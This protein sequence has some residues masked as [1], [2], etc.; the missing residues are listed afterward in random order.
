MMQTTKDDRPIGQRELQRLE[1]RRNLS[2]HAIRLFSER[3]FDQTTVEEIAAAAGVSTRTFFLHFPTK[4]AAAFPDH[5]E[6][7]EA[8]VQRLREGAPHADPMSHLRQ[9][10]LAGFD[11]TSPTRLI[12][13]SLLRESADLRDEDART[14][15]DYE[16]VIADFLIT[17]WG[18]SVEATVRAHAGANATIGVVRAALVAGAEHGLDA[19]QVTGEILQRMFGG[20]FDGPLHSVH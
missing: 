6:R 8:V 12:R 1:T 4:A 20:P 11:T 17:H 9:V 14:D 13:Y 3:G 16:L 2:E 15:R 5:G 18:S 19:R 10:I 7:V